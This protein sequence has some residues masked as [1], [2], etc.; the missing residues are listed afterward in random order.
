[1]RMEVDAVVPVGA[2][3]AAGFV[4]GN[5]ARLRAAGR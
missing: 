4:L 2:K 1:M 3:E 5:V